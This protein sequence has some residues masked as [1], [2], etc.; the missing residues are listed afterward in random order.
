MKKIP[1]F[2][3]LMALS[4]FLIA[5]SFPIQIALIYDHSI[6]EITTIMSKLT[7]LNY[8]VM[9]LLLYTSYLTL[10]IKARVF[11]VLPILNLFVFLNNFVVSE[12]GQLYGHFQTFLVST[13]FLLYTLTFYRKDIYRVYHDL[14]F[15]YWLTSPRFKRHL[16]VELHYKG[17]IIKTET[18]D[19]SKTGLFIKTDPYK[20]LLSIN[21]HQ[22]IDIVIIDK[23]KRIKLNA[24]IMR[25]CVAQGSYPEG[26]GVRI[27][28]TEESFMWNG[29]LEKLAKAAA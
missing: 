10:K 18:F 20:E 24:Y 5:L 14:K 28:H 23:R 16:P 2:V 3:P 17:N 12:Y 13:L 21:T 25:K 19:I 11:I 4:L 27:N 1:L 29:Q 7:P 8:I 6:F 9:G 22:D 26:I 15:R